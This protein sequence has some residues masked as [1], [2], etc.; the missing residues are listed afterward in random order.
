MSRSC[1]RCGVAMVMHAHRHEQWHEPSVC[2]QCLQN[3]PLRSLTVSAFRYEFPVQQMITG[4]KFSAQFFFLP[5]LVQALCAAL[6]NH[7]KGQSLP[8]VVLPVPL[9]R[10]RQVE[11]GFNQSH[12][13]A[14][15]LCKNMNIPIL[16]GAVTRQVNT[17][18]QVQLMANERQKNLRQ[19]FVVNKVTE[20]QNRHI[21]IVDDVITTGSTVENLA[22]L[23]IGHGAIR[24]DAWCLARA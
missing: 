17:Q 13:I 3:T 23:L 1:L 9:H 15:Y 4:F 24:V 21:A 11:R 6:S 14:R 18:P 16:K 20:I 5:P 10:K 7:Y 8:Q 2:G 22:D 19:A 12:L